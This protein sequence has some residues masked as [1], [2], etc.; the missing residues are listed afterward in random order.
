V[1]LLDCKADLM[2]NRFYFSG[3]ILTYKKK[4]CNL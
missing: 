2:C 3:F 4:S 1:D